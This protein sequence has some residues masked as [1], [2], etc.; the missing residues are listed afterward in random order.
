VEIFEV[1]RDGDG[2]LDARYTYTYDEH[3]LESAS[4][5][6][7]DC[8]GRPNSRIQS[9]YDE[10]HN[11]IGEE[12]MGADGVVQQRWTHTY[13]AA[14]NRITSEL[15]RYV[16]VPERANTTRFQFFYDEAGNRIRVTRDNLADGS[17]DLDCEYR[18]P[19]AS[20]VHRADLCTPPCASAPTDD[21]RRIIENNL[22]TEEPTPDVFVNAVFGD[23]IELIG[24][25]IQPVPLE[26][27]EDL[28][29]TWY[30]R[31][32]TIIEGRWRFM[33]ELTGNHRQT[34]AHEAIDGLFHT[35]EWEPGNII[36]DQQ[37]VTLDGAFVDSQVQIDLRLARSRRGDQLAPT[38]LGNCQQTPDITYGPR[39]I[40]GSFAAIRPIPRLEAGRLDIDVTDELTIDGRLNERAWRGSNRTDLWVHPNTG[41]PD[42][43]VHGAARVLWD[44]DALYIGMQAR[45]RDIWAT[46]TERDGNLWEEEVLAVM[47]DP[48][49]DGLNY[50]DLEVNP[51]GTLFDAVFPEATNR[52]PATARATQLEGLQWAAHVNGTVEDREQVDRRWSVEIRIPWNALPDASTPAVGD[53]IAANFFR[54]D[55]S[56]D[57]RAAV[58]IWSPVFGGSFHQPDKFGTIVL[59]DR[60][61]GRQR[62]RTG[63]D[64]PQ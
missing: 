39:L 63:S 36:R 59:S 4:E 2:G 21:E 55:R 11:L 43:G 20:E 54:F 13:D 1:D 49:S 22:L 29:I 34:S 37:T 58:S 52:D 9:T 35:N 12:L 31:A 48:G 46:M 5:W 6:D 61:P 51:L 3:G 44:V 17:I 15:G 27:G 26:A 50:V 18:P 30:W 40:V 57:A 7:S 19:C 23:E 42:E 10:S 38:S 8:D 14:G 53:E 16:E 62:N 41:E 47:L 33:V 28:T 24:Y 25:D 64:S 32:L 60:T 45:D 56:Q